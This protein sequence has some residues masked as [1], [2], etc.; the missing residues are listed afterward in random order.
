MT[1]QSQLPQSRTHRASPEPGP[2]GPAD[3][4]DGACPSE[5]FGRLLLVPRAPV[6]IET[7]IARP[8]LLPGEGLLA[9]AMWVA[10]YGSRRKRRTARICATMV[11]ALSFVSV[12]WTAAVASN[13]TTAVSTMS[14]RSL[15][16]SAPD[17]R[18]CA[19]IES[20]IAAIARAAVS[21]SSVRW[22]AVHA[23]SPDAA[24]LIR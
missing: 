4:Q 2:Y 14:E 12:G 8:A 24:A 11:L 20:N 16:D 7:P 13:F 9:W 5:Q 15:S 1:T 22:G 17:S 21:G 18:S 23:A 19:N 3:G 6:F 10:F